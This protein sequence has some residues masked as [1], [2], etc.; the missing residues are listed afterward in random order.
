MSISLFTIGYE[1]AVI[2]DFIKILAS[3]QGL[4]AN[5]KRGAY[6]PPFFLL[7]LPLFHQN[8]KSILQI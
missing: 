4:N 2:K 6:E 1:G 5:N 8:L 3:N 7:R